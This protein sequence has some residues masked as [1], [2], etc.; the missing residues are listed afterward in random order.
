[1]NESL[2]QS[3]SKNGLSTTCTRVKQGNLVKTEDFLSS[4]ALLSSEGRS[5]GILCDSHLLLSERSKSEEA[6]CHLISTLTHS[7][8]GRT[9]EMVKRSVVPGMRA[10]RNE[11]TEHR[12]SSGQ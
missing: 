6:T 10:G 9:M 1:M 7:A 4:L 3:S 5:A 12:G 8:K 2:Y 11:Q